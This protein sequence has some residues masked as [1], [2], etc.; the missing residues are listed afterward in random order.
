MKKNYYLKYFIISIVATVAISL[1]VVFCFGLDNHNSYPLQFGLDLL[2]SEMVVI[3][4]LRR[5]RLCSDQG[6][7][8]GK[9]LSLSVI[10]QLIK[11]IVTLALL[12]VYVRLVVYLNS[13]ATVTGD[14]VDDIGIA[15]DN[16][17]SVSVYAMAL[18]LY[19]FYYGVYF[20]CS[21]TP[22]VIIGLICARKRRQNISA[23]H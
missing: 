17:L 9:A 12:Y 3:L 7:S 4:I 16:Y 23:T 11:P 8:R 18:N 20:F 5:L 22:G 1:I 14:A 15:L 6:V 21:I 19:I 13:D 10:S 2:L